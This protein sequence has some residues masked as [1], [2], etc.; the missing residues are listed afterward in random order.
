MKLSTLITIFVGFVLIFG[1]TR[2]VTVNQQVLIAPFEL[3]RDLTLP[4]YAIIGIAFLAGLML[5]I[6]TR[7][8]YVA[9]DWI[10]R[11]KS[12]RQSRGSADIE[13]TYMEGEEAILNGQ[14]EMA[15]DSFREVL[16]RDPEH[17]SALLKAGEVARALGQH[18]EAVRMHKEAE[19][20]QPEDLRALYGLVADYEAMGSTDAAREVLERIIARHPRHPITAYR[21][22]RQIFM[23]A[24][25]W[26]QAAEIQDKILRLVHQNAY[27]R[28]AE[29]RYSLGIQ[30]ERSCM[31]LKQER[32]KD[33]ATA[34]RKIIKEKPDFVPARLN[35]GRALEISGNHKDALETWKQGFQTTGS[36]VFLTAIEDHLLDR[37][38]PQ[39]AIQMLDDL[40]HS[41][42]RPLL[43]RFHLGCLYLRLEMIDDA[44]RHF[45]SIQTEAESFPAFH[46]YRGLALERRGYV[47]QAVEAFRTALESL[48]LPRIEYECTVCKK[49]YDTWK[50]RCEKCGEW[51]RVEMHLPPGGPS[52]E[53]ISSAP[54]YSARER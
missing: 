8:R 48:D 6:L 49:R 7:L 37:E 34:F 18:D 35:L 28:E 20:L 5:A 51:N 4:I 25:E 44:H 13:G 45:E 26:D 38:S 11:L 3:P 47:P 1:M 23:S 53:G 46:Y 9:R 19:R 2:L 32:W 41:P 31:I 39:Q 36:A 50:D 33:A 30:Y 43:P 42:R 52:E 17:R 54:I 14:K 29:A 12:H 24:D 16:E 10:R 27:A 22:L 40:A 21:K 15:L